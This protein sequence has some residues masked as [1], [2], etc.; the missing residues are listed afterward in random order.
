MANLLSRFHTK[1]FPP[2]E[3]LLKISQLRGT[4]LTATV[5]AYRVFPLSH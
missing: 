3:V 5:E 1:S 2:F 4:P